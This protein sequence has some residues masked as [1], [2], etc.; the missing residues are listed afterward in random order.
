MKVYVEPEIEIF[1][2]KTENI[3]NDDDLGNV[4]GE[5]DGND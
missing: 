5:D 2:F 3:T 4:S 1:R